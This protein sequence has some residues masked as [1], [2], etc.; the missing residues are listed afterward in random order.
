MA[1]LIIIRHP[2]V[3]DT[4]ICYGQINPPCELPAQDFEVLVDVLRS[5]LS[6][7]QLST[8]AKGKPVRLWSSP[9]ER[10]LLVTRPLEEAFSWKATL[11]ERLWELSM[12]EFEGR[13]KKELSTNEAFLNWMNNWQTLAPP[14]GETMAQMT[15][16]V[17]AWLQ[18]L[19]EQETHIVV[20]HA[21]VIRSL[22]V[23][24]RDI[25]WPEA[26]SEEV[27]HLGPHRFQFP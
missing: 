8:E 3:L 6:E 12:G 27:P 26:L 4:S 15:E 16:R 18:G 13:L 25:T 21:G 24:L 5:H 10:C 14:G 23:L 17:A 11:D 1:E 9:A 7:M 19:S 22:M 2:P 20:A